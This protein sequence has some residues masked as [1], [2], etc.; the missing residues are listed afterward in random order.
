MK[1]NTSVNISNMKVGTLLVIYVYMLVK[2]I[3]LKFNSL[4]LG[5]LWARLL[6]GLQQPSLFSQRLH[7]G[8]LVPFQEISRSM[9]SLTSHDIFNLFGNVAIFMPL[10]ILLGLMFKR[11]GMPGM[12]IFICA[13]FLSLGLEIAQLLFMIGQF[14]VDD[15]LLNSAGGFLGFVIYRLN[16]FIIWRGGESL[17]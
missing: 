9:H 7:T 4:D 8:N 17:H 16:T 1:T 12:R 10:G 6:A 15:I 5:F 13:F 2:I 3:L 14:D 11:E